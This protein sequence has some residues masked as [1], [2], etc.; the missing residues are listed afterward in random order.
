MGI[1]NCKFRG[2]LA[3]LQKLSY[4]RK[5]DIFFKKIITSLSKRQY[6]ITKLLAKGDF[7][8]VISA[9]NSINQNMAIKIQFLLLEGNTLLSRNMGNSAQLIKEKRQRFENEVI[10]MNK[11]NHINVVK[12]IDSFWDGDFFFIIMKESK[13]NLN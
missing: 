8:I 13:M 6:Y 10:M 7:G 5:Y 11:I 4:E 3:I 1:T 9:V 12:C 2:Q